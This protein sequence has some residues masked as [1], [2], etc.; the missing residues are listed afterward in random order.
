M[1]LAYSPWKRRIARDTADTLETVRRDLAG[2]T[3]AT[4]HAFLSVCQRLMDL[5]SRTRE[6]AARTTAIAALLS[7]DDGSAV[8]E[9]VLRPANEG[10]EREQAV[11]AVEAIQGNARDISRA[12]EEVSPLVRTF[13][14]LGIMTRIESA[15]FEAAGVTFTGLADSVAT[16]SR[17]I[18]EQMSTTADSSAVLVE[19]IAVAAEQVRQAAQSRRRILAPLTRQIAAGLLKIR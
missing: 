19:T 8:L 18:R 14:V 6:I 12:I 3:G 2:F 4:E 10:H 1:P 9:D 7:K 5:Q 11:Q 16:L 15:R 17:Q 13:D